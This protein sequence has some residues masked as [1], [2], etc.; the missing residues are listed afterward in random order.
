MI[1]DGTE[2]GAL[3]TLSCEYPDTGRPN[4]I[5]WGKLDLNTVTIPDTKA[6]LYD[7]NISEE[8]SSAVNVWP[9]AGP[10][11]AGADQY[12]MIQPRRG[13]QISRVLVI[14]QEVHL[15]NSWSKV[16]AVNAE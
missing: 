12:F 14:G 3:M 11:I 15:Y 5:K 1:D 7:I 9:K 10:V 6:N 8:T 16:P 4:S 2:K 13:H